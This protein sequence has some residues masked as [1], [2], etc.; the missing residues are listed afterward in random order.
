MIRAIEIG[1]KE[2]EFKASAVTSILYKRAFKKDLTSEFSEYVKKY[3]L[4]KALKD[5]IE[6][7]DENEKI[8]VLSKNAEILELSNAAQ[9]LFPQLAYIMYLEANVE[10]R[11]IF[12]KLSEEEFIFWLSQFET[13]DFQNH[14]SDFMEMWNSNAHTSVKPKN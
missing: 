5:D 11:E 12:K 3:R 14:Y 10:Q 1:G 6:N 2:I 4:V 9:E 13:A 8:D 7:K